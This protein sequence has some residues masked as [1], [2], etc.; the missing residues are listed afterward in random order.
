MPYPRHAARLRC[1]PARLVGVSMRPLLAHEHESLDGWAMGLRV[2]DWLRQYFPDFYGAH[3]ASRTITTARLLGAVH[4][5]LE[6]AN[7]E[8]VTLDLT[9]C[10]LDIQA[11]G[12]PAAV[13]DS[14]R[15]E[16]G[17]LWEL[18]AAGGIRAWL[19]APA[20]LVYGFDRDASIWSWE[21]AQHDALGAV[22]YQLTASTHWAWGGTQAAPAWAFALGQLD[23]D[24][25]MEQLADTCTWSC[26]LPGVTR[27][28][29][30]QVLRYACRQTGNW[31]A[32]TTLD[33]QRMD[34]EAGEYDLWDRPADV[35]RIGA[36]QADARAVQAAY[37]ALSAAMAQRPSLITAVAKQLIQTSRRL[38]TG[39]PSRTLVDSMAE[40]GVLQ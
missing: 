19:E 8:L 15:D 28:T 39:R 12:D 7:R 32:D 24:T 33:E 10:P 5:W 4:A 36:A 3:L 16:G 37:R 27:W 26:P 2:A 29:L 13:I 9:G 11:E 38:I 40:A 22:L 23:P 31:Y 34:D 21:H 14:Y 20:P 25:D 17:M 35:A 1:R 30:G 6:L 18:S